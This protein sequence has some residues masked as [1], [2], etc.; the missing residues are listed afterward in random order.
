M[1]STTTPTRAPYF[2]EQ[3]MIGGSATHVSSLASTFRSNAV[4][5]PMARANPRENADPYGIHSVIGP[6]MVTDHGESNC[7]MDKENN[8]E[9]KY[10]K[11]MRQVNKT[12]V[13][14]LD[15]INVDLE[16]TGQVE[17]DDDWRKPRVVEME[18]KLNEQ[19][20]VEK[21]G[22]WEYPLLWSNYGDFDNLSV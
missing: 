1:D 10:T 14:F 12:Y 9:Y 8:N 19:Q 21:E 5:D 18:G 4:T 11:E 13:N 22:V 7:E 2:I 20:T 15:W 17:I 3:N 6:S 16:N